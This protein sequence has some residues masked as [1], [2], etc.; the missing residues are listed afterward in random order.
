[1]ES[2]KQQE[3]YKVSRP[4]VYRWVK[5]YDGMQ[6]SLRDFSHRPKS[7]PNQH[8]EEALKLIHNIRKWNPHAGLVVFRV[9]L[10]Q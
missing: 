10:R 6:E 8:P 9:K 2:V 7:H 4:T 1:M 3:K 5:R